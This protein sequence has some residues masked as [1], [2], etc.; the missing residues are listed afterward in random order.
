MKKTCYYIELTTIGNDAGSVIKT[1]RDMTGLG[2]KEAKDKVEAAPCVLLETTS[3][4]DA[5]RYKTALETCGATVTISSSIT[6][7]SS[8]ETKLK[9]IGIG[10]I[11]LNLV[12]VFGGAA[13]I[14][15]IPHIL[16]EMDFFSVFFLMAIIFATLC[17]T[18]NFSNNK[19]T[20]RMVAKT[21]KKN[22]EKY[23][24]DKSY[25]FYTRNA[26]IMIDAVGGRIAYISNLNPWKFQ[27]ISAKDIAD[28]KSDYKK[29]VLP[30]TTHYVYFQFSYLGNV[31]KIPTFT[32]NHYRPLAMDKV[33]EGLKNAARYAEILTATKQVAFCKD[34]RM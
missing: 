15:G 6:D 29:G 34:A 28:I 10:F 7:V 16:I 11:I 25:T 24:F 19:Y 30:E 17:T 21:V 31:M 9:K 20:D 18:F 22:A 3:M 1:Y 13:V 32:S 12:V 14:A 5:E 2:L 26:T 4:E 23:S 27:M 8:Q 33:Q